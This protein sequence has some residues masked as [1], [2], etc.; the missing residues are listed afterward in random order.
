MTED[1][2]SLSQQRFGQ[3]A[4]SYVTSRSHAGG[5]DLDRLVEMAAPQPGWLALDI[6]TGGGHTAL[7]IAPQVRHVIAGD[8]TPKMLH[9]AR[10]F[11]SPQAANVSYLVTDAEY[12]AFAAESLDLITCRIAPHHFPDCFRFVQECTRALKPGGRLVIQDHALPDDAAAGRYIDAFETL[13]DPSHHRA[14][15]EYEWRGMYLDAGLKVDQ[16]EIMRKS[17]GRMITWAERQGCPPDVIE[18]LHVMLAQA[19]APVKT[20]INPVCVGTADAQF[21]HV[22]ILIAGTK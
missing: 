10:D 8:L 11:L 14:F 4:E 16:V 1:S 12:L 18:R 13:R 20:W 6:A 7:K 15:A 17:G 21:D 2:K 22:Y 5:D 9:A 3:F 19:P